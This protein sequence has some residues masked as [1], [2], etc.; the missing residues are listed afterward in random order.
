MLAAAAFYVLLPASASVSRSSFFGAYL[1]AQI[2]GVV[3]N[4]PG[5]L[6]VFETVMLLLLSSFIS[7]ATILGALLVYRGIYYFLPLIVAALLLGTYEL[8]RGLARSKN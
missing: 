8:R 7:S 6:G 4:V 2:A 1:L 3:S 5:G